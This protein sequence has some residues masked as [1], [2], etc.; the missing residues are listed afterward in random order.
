MRA[1][2]NVKERGKW[3]GEG[4]GGWE[5]G[6]K[7]RRG[8]LGKGGLQS[9]V[10]TD[11][12]SRERLCVLRPPVRWCTSIK[13]RNRLLLQP[14]MCEH[15]SVQGL[16][17][18]RWVKCLT[19]VSEAGGNRTADIAKPSAMLNLKG[20]NTLLLWSQGRTRVKHT[21]GY[22]PAPSL[23]VENSVQYKSE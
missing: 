13:E 23:G 10:E 8:E 14:E 11:N 6:R 7:E 20:K 1:Q 22:V 9:L 21:Q 2:P 18:V 16:D 12:A 19:G 3:L 15:T 17:C 5:R 4:S